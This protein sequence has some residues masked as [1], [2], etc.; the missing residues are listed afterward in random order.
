MIEPDLLRR[1]IPN[2][3]E[4]DITKARGI[5]EAYEADLQSGDASTWGELN[6]QFHSTLLEPARRPLSLGIVQNLNYHSH[7]YVRLQLMLTHGET[8]ATEEHRLILGYCERKECDAACG[9]LV[10]HIL[11]AGRSLVEYIMIRRQT[12]K[13]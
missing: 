8:R 7:R 13:K 9:L 11:H 10:E 2:L 4:A 12:T 6:W 3:T 5:L 1:A